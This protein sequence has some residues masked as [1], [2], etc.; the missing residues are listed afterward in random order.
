MGWNG[1]I[2]CRIRLVSGRRTRIH[3][4][5]K[6][7]FGCARCRAGSLS[8]SFGLYLLQG[9]EWYNVPKVGLGL[10]QMTQ[11]YFLNNP[12]KLYCVSDCGQVSIGGLKS[13]SLCSMLV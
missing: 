11:N 7:H 5:Y 2:D 10:A 6:S 4:Y 13:L 8:G 1:F 3:A 12:Q 9:I